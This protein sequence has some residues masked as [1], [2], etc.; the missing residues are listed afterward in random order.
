[1]VLSYDDLK[2]FDATGRRLE[3][4][5]KQSGPN[6][7]FIFV[8]DENATY[9]I[10]VDPLTSVKTYSESQSGAKFGTALT[11]GHFQST[12]D[13]DAGIV[14]GAPNFDNGAN[15]DVGKVFHYNAGTGT[16]PASATWTKL[17]ENAGD[18]FGYAVAK[19][20]FNGDLYEDLA[21]G[22][23]YFDNQTSADAGKV[24][25]FYGASTGLPSSASWTALPVSAA[26]PAGA[27]AGW[28]LTA[29]SLDDTLAD[30]YHDLAI[31]APGFDVLDGFDYDWDVGKVFV[32][33]SPEG[34]SGLQNSVGWSY[35]GPIDSIGS[36]GSQVGYSLTAIA[37]VNNSLEQH[38]VLVVGAPFKNQGIAN[39]T[40]GA[41]LLFEP[42]SSGKPSTPTQTLWGTQHYGWF[43]FSVA[44]FDGGRLDQRLSDVN[45]D[46]YNDLVVGAPEFSNGQ[47]AEGKIYVYDN[48]GSGGIVNSTPLFTKESNQAGA[49]F[50]YSV[51]CGDL[52]GDGKADVF[53]GAPDWD[54]TGALNAGKAFFFKSSGTALTEDTSSPTGASAN[55]R[56]GST[57]A[58]GRYVEGTLSGVTG[59]IVG[60]PNDSGG[61][62]AVWK[63]SP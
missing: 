28:S 33:Y 59:L 41:V 53:V 15:A 4:Q 50:G 29:V 37:D 14:V 54:I 40:Y 27:N 21:I 12:A 34:G 18:Q 6:G 31:G 10:L 46:Q 61:A 38:S 55:I 26:D 11:N 42:G 57:I 36:V 63:Y 16:L 32:Y 58:F 39:T 52:D 23:P 44:S 45:D 60:V 19:G 17:G 62:V 1:M 49:H 8:N 35:T 7:F 3:A 13:D 30:D 2:V 20:K 9:P 5:M 24:Y 22:A 47:T 56:M 43:G 25:V 51:A 48:S